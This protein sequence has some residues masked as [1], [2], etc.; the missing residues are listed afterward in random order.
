MLTQRFTKNVDSAVNKAR[1]RMDDLYRVEL[2]CEETKSTEV[3]SLKLQSHPSTFLDIKKAI[4]ESFS[5]PVCV[6][7]LLHQ[8]CK[9]A[10]QDDP[11]SSYIR[12]GDTF[13]VHYPAKGDC[14]RV[15][16]AVK[17]LKQL[18]DAV[19]HRLQYHRLGTFHSSLITNDYQTLVFE[20]ETS[21]DFCLNLMYPWTDKTKY[22][23]KLHFDSLGGVE[24][25][26]NVYNTFVTARSH[27]IILF[28]SH[29]MEVVCS[30]FVANFTHTFP[31]RRRILEHGGLELSMKTFLKSQSVKGSILPFNDAVEVS[32]YAICK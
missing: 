17:W 1:Q 13:T 14:E 25:A 19:S 29:Y 8:S 20:D 3:S 9:V 11:L 15:I 18:A 24:L 7:T 12:S 30:L 16:K 2:V 6:Q 23:N 21:R 22:V 26:L 32:I 31:L 27:E 5:V 28:K 4:E 10:D